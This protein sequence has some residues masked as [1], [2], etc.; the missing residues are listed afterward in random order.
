MNTRPPI[1][2]ILG[3]VDHGKTT[4][5]DYIRKSSVAA[6]EHGGITQKIGA[7]EIT[8]DIKG[9]SNNKITFI[10]TPGH[11]AFSHLRARGAKIADIAILI[12]DAKDSVMPQT[13]ESISHIKSAQIP[14]IV[15][16]NKSDLPEA[17]PEKVKNDLLKYEF[18]TE[19]KGGK[20]PSILLSAKTGEGVHNL[21][22]TI[23]LIAEDQHL[24]YD[25]DTNP[26]A[27][28]IETKK[29]RRGIVASVII[30]NGCLKIGDIVY[31]DIIKAKIRSMIDDQGENIS[32][33]FPSMPFELLGFESLPDIGSRISKITQA[34]QTIKTAAI[35]KK[36][37]TLDEILNP[38][39]VEKKLS[40]ILKTDSYG[41]LEAISSSLIKND[42][43]KVILKAVGD[44]NKSDIFLAK[45][46]KSIIIGFSTIIAHEVKELAKQEKVVIKTYNIIYELLEEL[47]EV[48]TLMQEKE[49]KEKNLKGEAK[50]LASFII[51]GEKVFGVKLTK[52]KINLGDELSLF[53]QGNLIAKTKLISLKIR[54]KPMTEVKKEQEAGILVN[55]QLDIRVGDVVQSIL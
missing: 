1:V 51:D 26:E 9:Y 23:L 19:D 7:Y 28:I 48:A 4:L 47:D 14:C 12:I 30:K 38:K 54:A 27:Y 21:L 24:T 36:T 18:M 10:D 37:V 43:I 17:N 44:I 20:I 53:R 8:T 11:E 39:V 52:G 45:T 29:D 3:H 15:A 34:S 35:E 42:Q 13:I 22:E 41:S 50:I 2:T 32:E 31:S 55:P 33:A 16:L 40:L 25:K 5:L 6:K 49:Q 46:T